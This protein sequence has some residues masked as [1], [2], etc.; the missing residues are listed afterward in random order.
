MKKKK[1]LPLSFLSF[2]VFCCKLFSCMIF[3]LPFL[4][5][6]LLCSPLET[7]RSEISSSSLTSSPAE[8]LL[9]FREAEPFEIPSDSGLSTETE[10][11]NDPAPQ[12][13]P[14]NAQP[15]QYY[16]NLPVY[17][18]ATKAI[19]S[20]RAIASVI[21]CPKM[22]VGDEAPHVVTE[23]YCFVVDGDKVKLQVLLR[24]SNITV[25]Q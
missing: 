19:D 14:S 25:V 22:Y 2:C 15:V 11:T 18:M 7:E 1:T 13:G 3:I 12:P 9:D 16:Q 23:N 21:S 24:I 20:E 5:F 8:S 17:S 6:P 4:S 10:E